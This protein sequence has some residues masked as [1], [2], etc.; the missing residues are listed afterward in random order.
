[1]GELA[2]LLF[3]AWK[4]QAKMLDELRKSAADGQVQ[5]LLAKEK[6]GTIFEATA[7]GRKEM[8]ATAEAVLKKKADITVI[9]LNR[10]GEVVVMS[11]TKDAGSIA[12]DLCQK[13]GGSGGGSQR[14]GQGRADFEKMMG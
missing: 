13:A 7:F 9:L 4:K 3:S 8:I 10:Q 12:R 5:S 11:G 14:L 1:M 2:A 6:D